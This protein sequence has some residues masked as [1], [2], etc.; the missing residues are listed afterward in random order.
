MLIHPFFATLPLSHFLSAPDAF[1][2]E[3]KE[4][5]PRNRDNGVYQTFDRP[6]FCIYRIED[7]PSGRVSTGLVALT[8][9]QDYANGR[10]KEHERTIPLREEQQKALIEMWQGLIKPVLLTYP[11]VPVLSAYIQEATERY[12]VALS[13]TLPEQKQ[14]HRFW[15][16]DQEADIRYVQA[17]FQTHLQQVYIADGHH[18]AT[19]LYHLYERTGEQEFGGMFSA[20]FGTDQLQIGAFHRVAILS[21]KFAAADH[22]EHLLLLYFDLQPLPDAALPSEKH[23]MILFFQGRWHLLSWKEAVL[24]GVRAL[25]SPETVLLDTWLLDLLLK[26]E[27]EGMESPLTTEPLRY[28]EGKEGPEKVAAACKSPLHAGFLLYPVAFEDFQQVSDTNGIMPPKSTFFEPRLK[29][30]LIVLKKRKK[31]V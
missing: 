21:E 3:A 12:P 7:L 2:K 24:E 9:M 26:G 23:R 16:V 20:L 29:S 22:L 8:N 14:T 13:V 30:G 17:L 6:A 4:A 15:I 10:I 25:H 19:A 1:C 28:I 27:L 31:E 18:R 11:A 5:Y